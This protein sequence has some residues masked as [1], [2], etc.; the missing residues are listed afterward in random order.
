MLVLLPLLLWLLR[1]VTRKL[2]GNH[3]RR[4]SITLEISLIRC[5][6]VQALQ[7]HRTNRRKKQ[8]ER[9][10]DNEESALVIMQAEKPHDLPP[11]S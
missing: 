10:T 9:Q 1:K 4:L 11:A 8:I 7:R 3:N 6:L 2:R 5:V